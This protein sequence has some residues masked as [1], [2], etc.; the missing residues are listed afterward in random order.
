MD[1]TL[2]QAP[3]L[4][5]RVCP[6]PS[7]SAFTVSYNLFLISQFLFYFDDDNDFSF[8]EF[9]AVNFVYPT[10]QHLTEDPSVSLFEFLL[11]VKSWV[12]FRLEI[13]DLTV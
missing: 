11:R 12:E 3:V 10:D 1:R 8:R 7:S 6:S 2:F 13:Q 9:Y 4:Q 5:P